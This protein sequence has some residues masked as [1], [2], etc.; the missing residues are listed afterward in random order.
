MYPL[1]MRP[2]H[3]PHTC[4]TCHTGNEVEVKMFSA[5]GWT[6]EKGVLP[7]PAADTDTGALTDTPAA[8][9]AADSAA[10]LY[11]PAPA[12]APGPGSA[13]GSAAPVPTSV[14][15]VVS[16]DRRVSYRVL[17]R[18]EFDHGRQCM[19]VVVESVQTGKR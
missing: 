3:T 9:P 4:H 14:T 13:P 2:A 17:R 11:A 12:P 6:L 16:P 18:F 8:S 15:V 1:C 5:T 10:L 7:P 19:S